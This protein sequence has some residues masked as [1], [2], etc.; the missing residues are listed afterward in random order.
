MKYRTR[1]FYTDQQKSEMWDPSRRCKHR[2]PAVGGNAV[3][4]GARLAVISIVRRLRFFLIWRELVGSASLV[5][6]RSRCALSLIDR[7]EISRGLVAKLSFRLIAQ[8]LNRSASTIS[9]EV[10][11]SGGRQAYRAAPSGQRAWDSATRPKLCKL[12]FNDPLCQLMARKLRRKWSPQQ[13]AGWRKHRYRDEEPNRVSHALTPR[14]QR[15]RVLRSN[16]PRGG[17]YIAA[18]MSKPAGFCRRNYRN[19]CAVHVRSDAP[20]TPLRRALSYAKSR[21]LFQ[22]ANARLRSK[23]VP[24]RDIDGV[25]ASPLNR[26]QSVP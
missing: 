7:E 25:D 4:Q 2:L 17:R 15:D 1:T 16:V 5:A 20:G 26:H 13:I 12:S 11:K 10:R 23:I 22:L 19:V 21:M 24:F 3:I 6:T 18:S 14:G 9:R 8:I